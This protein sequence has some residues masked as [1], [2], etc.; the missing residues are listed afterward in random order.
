VK[1]GDLVRFT[2]EHS[3]RPGYDYCT[4][5]TGVI[6]R[7]PNDLPGMYKICWSTQHGTH[8]GVWWESD[9]FRGLELISEGR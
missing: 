8:T 3:S 6:F 2:K 7:D 9:G 5:W 1:V 4:T